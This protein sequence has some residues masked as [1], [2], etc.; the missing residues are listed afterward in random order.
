MSDKPGKAIDIFLIKRSNPMALLSGK[1]YDEEFS[2]EIIPVKPSP[3]GIKDAYRIRLRGNDNFIYDKVFQVPEDDILGH[4]W[5]YKI[6]YAFQKAEHLI[7]DYQQFSLSAYPGKPEN[8]AIIADIDWLQVILEGKYKDKISGNLTKVLVRIFSLNDEE[9]DGDQLQLPLF[10]RVIFLCSADEAIQFGRVL[11]DE[12]LAAEKL[13]RELG[14]P[15]PG[16]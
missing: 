12:C 2:L 10:R 7:T 9:K 1:M 8:I 13:R 14:I 16:D 5:M 4:H 11:E 6:S 15:H 3:F